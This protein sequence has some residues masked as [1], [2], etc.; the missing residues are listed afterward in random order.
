MLFILLLNGGVSLTELNFPTFQMTF[1]L[2]HIVKI[3]YLKNRDQQKEGLVK[4]LI[5]WRYLLLCK[6]K[7]IVLNSFIFLNFLKLNQ[8]KIQNNETYQKLDENLNKTPGQGNFIS[9]DFRS[10]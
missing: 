8:V 7:T 4:N 9:D 6:R 3:V 10:N 2:K 5:A 1:H